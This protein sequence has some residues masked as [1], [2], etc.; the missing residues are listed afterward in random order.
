MSRR[1]CIDRR[2]GEYRSIGFLGSRGIK[3]VIRVLAEEGTTFWFQLSKG[4]EV[5]GEEINIAGTVTSSFSTAL[6]YDRPARCDPFINFVRRE[7]HQFVN[8]SVK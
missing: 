3:E 1:G 7:N 2:V 4:M 5:G 6:E 8:Q